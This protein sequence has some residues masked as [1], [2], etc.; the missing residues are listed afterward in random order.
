MLAPASL[1]KRKCGERLRIRSVSGAS[2]RD[3]CL[4]ILVMLDQANSW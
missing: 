3:Y 2:S 4:V 1:M